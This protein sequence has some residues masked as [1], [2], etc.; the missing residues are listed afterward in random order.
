MTPGLVRT[1]ELVAAM[2][3]TGLI[4]AG[5]RGLGLEAESGIHML[6]LSLPAALAIL[7]VVTLATED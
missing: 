1:L 2:V 3:G 6:N 7:V 4:A 5:W